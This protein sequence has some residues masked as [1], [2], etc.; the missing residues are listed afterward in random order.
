MNM[1][2]ILKLKIIKTAN[3]SIYTYVTNDYLIN[4]YLN[5]IFKLIYV[6]M[7]ILIFV[8]NNKI[9]QHINTCYLTLIYLISS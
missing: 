2:K 1:T 9:A 5:L 8:Y 7:I 4:I 3:I 6:L